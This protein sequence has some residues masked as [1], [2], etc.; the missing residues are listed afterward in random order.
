MTECLKNYGQ[1][2][3]VQGA[4][5]KAILKRKQSKKAKR[6]VEEALQIAGEQREGKNE[7]GKGTSN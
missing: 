2:S 7:R 1:R 5:N 4:G 6:L 3:I